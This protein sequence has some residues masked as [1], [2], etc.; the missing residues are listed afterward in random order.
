MNK[1]RS[2]LIRNH[3]AKGLSQPVKVLFS[4]L[5][6]LDILEGS[7]SSDLQIMVILSKLL[8]LFQV[9]SSKII[10]DNRPL[11]FP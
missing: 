1:L 7:V 3:F 8:S 9:E 2:S 6:E 10:L 4:S 5:V 11:S